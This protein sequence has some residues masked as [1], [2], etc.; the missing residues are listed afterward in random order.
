VLACWV[1]GKRR[2]R[3][4][5]SAGTRLSG[6]GGRRRAG[7]L[8]LS[9]WGLWGGPVYKRCAAFS[10][11]CPRT[12]HCCALN[13]VVA[14]RRADWLR[15][16]VLRCLMNGPVVSL[17]RCSALLPISVPSSFLSHRSGP[18]GAR[19]SKAS[20][21]LVRSITIMTALHSMNALMTPAALN[22]LV[23][24]TAYPPDLILV[25]YA[26]LDMLYRMTGVFSF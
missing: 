26:V 10:C 9:L 20:Q 24:V 15:L 22:C 13:G 11:S 5:R 18:L 25:S 23:L 6:A 16:A 1:R 17:V 12:L 19:P 3:A 2:R 7:G 21:P 14:L 4:R 8:R